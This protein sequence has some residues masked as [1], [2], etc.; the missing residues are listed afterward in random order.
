MNCSQIFKIIKDN[1]NDHTLINFNI[2][3]LINDF[4]EYNYNDIIYN[5]IIDID[6]PIFVINFLNKFID[7]IPDYKDLIII[8]I[9]KKTNI[10]NKLKHLF[11][12]DYANNNMLFNIYQFKNLTNNN[13]VD[14]LDFIVI[15]GK[16]DIIIELLNKYFIDKIRYVNI[17]TLITSL[18][19]YHKSINDNYIYIIFTK[20]LINFI[21]NILPLFELTEII[22]NILIENYNHS[23]TLDILGS[24]SNV[25]NNTLDI[26]GS[27]SNVENNT[28]DISN[29]TNRNERNKLELIIDFYIYVIDKFSVYFDIIAI[30]NSVEILNVIINNKLLVNNKITLINKLKEIIIQNY[31]NIHEKIDLFTNLMKILLRESNENILDNFVIYIYFIFNNI[32]FL[33]WMN[34]D[35]KIII[36]ELLAKIF[37]KLKKYKKLNSDYSDNILYYILYYENECF[38]LL[39]KILEKN[40]DFTLYNLIKGST[41]NLLTIIN[42]FIDIEDYYFENIKDKYITDLFYK[43]NLNMSVMINYLINN[44]N[45]LNIIKFNSDILLKNIIISKLILIHKYSD[46]DIFPYI[47]IDYE[48]YEKYIN[49]KNIKLFN[50]INVK[51]LILKNKYEDMNKRLETLNPLHI[52]NIFN[53][54]INDPVLLPN[55]NDLF[56]KITMMLLLRETKKHPYTREHITINNLLEYNNKEDIKNKIKIIFK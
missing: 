5:I 20:L 51:L 29:S 32:N 36:F 21:N 28:L 48:N 10:T 8:D 4:F 47:G 16:I 49:D 38:N 54:E 30:N 22:N 19:S 1:I 40:I 13:Y 24:T 2:N 56:E 12:L 34:I 25:E 55:C 11:L 37:M 7:S 27:T 52:D 31:L 41:Y 42:I 43:N 15:I 18:I 39:T 26:L 44:N 35:E 9:I 23:N 6:D 53:I 50:D 17:F 3:I 45:L 33:E 14:I 46:L